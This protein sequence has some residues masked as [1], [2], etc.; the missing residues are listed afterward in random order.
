MNTPL[1]VDYYSDVLCVWAW[2][3]QRR[4]DELNAQLGDKIEIR[5]YYMDVFGDV[6]KNIDTQWQQRGGY[7]AF[8][9]HV[10]QAAASFDDAPINSRIWTEVRPVTSA[11]AHLSLKAV[12][13]AYDRQASVDVALMLRNRFFNEAR[14][15]GRLD[16]ILQLTGDKGFDPGLIN[17]R[18][19]DGT[20]MAA[21]MR[22]YQAARENNIKGSPSYVIDG[23]RQILYGNV[24]YRV[25]HSNIEELLKHPRDEASWC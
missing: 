11:N 20:A 18:I 3:A 15:I 1:V 4:I 8:A 10:A 21:L 2:I 14:D 9:E 25:I 13:L 23:G 17:Q 12:E 5:R 19:A 24:G 16:V 7:A 6:A 22:D